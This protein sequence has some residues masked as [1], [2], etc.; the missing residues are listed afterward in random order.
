MFYVSEKATLDNVILEGD[1]VILGKSVIGE[2]TILGNNVI[3][4]Y[5]VRRKSST[6]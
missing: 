3:V 1:V 4:G 5:P 6:Y 2:H